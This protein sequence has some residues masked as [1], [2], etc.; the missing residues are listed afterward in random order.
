MMNLLQ[1]EASRSRLREGLDVFLPVLGVTVAAEH[2]T[3]LAVTEVE[4]RVVFRPALQVRDLEEGRVSRI[5]SH[6]V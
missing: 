4:G 6:I 3:V 2:E 5:V 1:H